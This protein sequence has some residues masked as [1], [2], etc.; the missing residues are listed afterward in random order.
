MPSWR[1]DRSMRWTMSTI[2]PKRGCS[3]LA[4]VW[5][6]AT[7]E[8]AQICPRGNG[9]VRVDGACGVVGDG[10][11]RG[12]HAARADEPRPCRVAERL[13]ESPIR[14]GPAR[15]ARGIGVGQSVGG[16]DGTGH[17]RSGFRPCAAVDRRSGS[18]D[19]GRADRRA[20][21]WLA[22]AYL[23]AADV[24][25]AGARR[26]V[27]TGLD[28]LADH[29]ATLGATDLRVGASTHAGQLA[30]R[31]SRDGD[32]D[33]TATRGARVGG[34]G[35]RERSCRSADSPAR[36]FAARSRAGRASTVAER[37]RR[38][39]TGGRRRSDGRTPAV[40]RQEVDGARSGPVGPR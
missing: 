38:I 13:G 12:V 20:N 9:A 15:L 30:R 7:C 29:Q 32:R 37:T 18:R 23:R 25:R 21:A 39:P 28:M 6:R 40:R 10:R 17:R 36:R 19:A 22:T 2:S 35:S 16:G 14:L 26:A 31:R 33:R 34:A 1:C 27:T 4:R 24:D 8:R 5:R 3:W 11:V